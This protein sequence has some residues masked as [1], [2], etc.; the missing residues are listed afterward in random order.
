[1]K[2][3]TWVTTILNAPASARKKIK[4]AALEGMKF[5]GAT[6]KNTDQEVEGPAQTIKDLLTGDKLKS[7]DPNVQKL[8]ADLMKEKAM[9]FIGFVPEITYIKESGPKDHLETMW[10]HPF[11][12]PTLLYAHEELPVLIIAGPDIMFNDSMVRSIKSNSKR[13]GKVFGVTG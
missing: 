13:Q 5:F 2:I 11:G 8:V 6:W 4:S 12:S 10:E 9:K 7:K 3:Q 1:M